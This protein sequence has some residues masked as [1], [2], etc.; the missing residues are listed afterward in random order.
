MHK[1]T[2]ITH[3]IVNH[4]YSLMKLSSTIVGAPKLLPTSIKVG[5]PPIVKSYQ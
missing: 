3:L 2:Q 1:C 5:S 4:R